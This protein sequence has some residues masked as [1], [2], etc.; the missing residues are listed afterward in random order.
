MPQ[1]E[2]EKKHVEMDKKRKPQVKLESPWKNATEKQIT[3][4]IRQLLKTLGIF[5]WKVHQGLGCVPGVP[6][7]IGIYQGRMLG[8]EIK[9]ERGTISD[10]QQRFLEAIN[11]EGGLAF[12]ARSAE[13]VIDKLGL[14]D[15]FLRL[16]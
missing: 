16:K 12:A 6:D 2:I 4:A 3:I 10:H 1:N 9:T 14:Q 15:R 11:R 8:I 7:I 13:D 5:H